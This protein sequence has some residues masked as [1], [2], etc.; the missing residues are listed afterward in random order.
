MVVQGHLAQDGRIQILLVAEAARL[1]DIGSVAIEA[2]R[3][4]IGPW[5]SALGQAVL[6]AP[7]LAQ[8]RLLAA[9][10][11]H[12]PHRPLGQFR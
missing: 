1:Q 5:H 2:F 10:L 4:A 12:H 3:H 11:L 9:P 7:C 6:Y 8:R